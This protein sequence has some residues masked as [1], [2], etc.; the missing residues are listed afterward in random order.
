MAGEGFPADASS[1]RRQCAWPSERDNHQ[2][3]WNFNQHQHEHAIAAVMERRRQ[4][5]RQR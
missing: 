1:G 4:I 3:L 5:T 2:R